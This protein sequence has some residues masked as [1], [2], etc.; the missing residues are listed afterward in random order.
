MSNPKDADRT[1]FF[2]YCEVDDQKGGL[3][4]WNVHSSF[5]ECDVL[6]GHA[7]ATFGVLIQRLSRYY[8]V[9]V[10][11]LLFLMSSLSFALFVL[12]LEDFGE[13]AKIFMAISLTQVTFKLSVENKLPKVAYSTAFDH[14]AITCQALLFT[15]A[16]ENAVVAQ[17]SKTDGELAKTVELICGVAFACIWLGW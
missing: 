9:N 11:T 8:I 12:N 1:F 3:E 2:Q 5:G 14:Y 16:I 10:M 7:Q 17:M 15:I 13:R 4:E 6:K